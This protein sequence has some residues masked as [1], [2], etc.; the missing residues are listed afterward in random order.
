M[1]PVV[2]DAP[3]DNDRFWNEVSALPMCQ[4]EISAMP[5]CE[6]GSIKQEAVKFTLWGKPRLET[7]WRKGEMPDGCGHQRGPDGA[8]LS[9]LVGPSFDE[10]A[11]SP[12]LRP[13][14]PRVLWLVF[15]A[16]G[17][18]AIE[19]ISLPHSR[20]VFDYDAFGAV[21]REYCALCA[22]NI[23]VQVMQTPCAFHPGLYCASIGRLQAD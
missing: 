2:C 15:H 6:S 20:D 12:T 23:P 7:E 9:S 10:S 18:S 4:A 21:P 14:F 13:L 22:R 17:P 8:E 5:T 11:I 16:V 19:M 3:H 1:F